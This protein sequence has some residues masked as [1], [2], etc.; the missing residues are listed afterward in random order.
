MDTT[1]E[2]PFNLVDDVDKSSGNNDFQMTM[3]GVAAKKIVE[4]T[5]DGTWAM[6]YAGNEKGSDKL[7]IT[8]SN[9]KITRVTANLS[10]AKKA[11]TVTWTV[12]PTAKDVKQPGATESGGG[13]TGALSEAV[14]AAIA[15]DAAN[16]TLDDQQA[17]AEDISAKGEAS[18]AFVKAKSAMDAGTKF[19][20]TLT[21]GETLEY[22]IIG[23]NHDDL[24][25][26]SGKAGL[27]FLTISRIP[28][29]RSYMNA[30]DTN[31]GGWKR[32]ELRAKMNEGEIWDLMPFDFRS[33]VK[34]VR[35]L[36]NNVGG[37]DANKDAAVTATSD[38]LF[39]LSA[40]EICSTDETATSDY[41]WIS[42]EGSQYEVFKPKEAWKNIYY[43]TWR[44]SVA[45]NNSTC[46][47]YLPRGVASS[48]YYR[49]GTYNDIFLPGV[50]RDFVL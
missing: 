48:K 39:L 35:K 31:A 43:D 23:I 11:A 36:T 22:R 20:M 7:P 45:G 49:A 34:A 5:D 12:E 41:S 24:A 17:V 46:F 29:L 27:T 18:P 1:A 33:K 8:I 38:K 30:T 16:W 25:D 44:R 26:G 47:L 9:A 42:K 21:D 37:G 14:Q 50:S 40:S 19:S 3:N 4:L 32:S 15:K 6:G 13:D 28:N 2:A 10:A